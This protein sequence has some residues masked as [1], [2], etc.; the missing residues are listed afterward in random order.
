MGGY[1]LVETC[2]GSAALTLHLLGARRPLLPYQGG[3]WRVRRELAEV[4]RQR[5]YHGAPSQVV[6][7][8]PG[9]WG[10]AAGAVVDGGVRE[11]VIERLVAF[12]ERDPREVYDALAGAAVPAERDAFAAEYLFLQRLSFSG[13]AVGVR[14]DRWI[15]PGFNPSSAYGLAG[16][17]RFGAVRPM[18]PSLI[19]VLRD[20][21]SLAASVVDSH[22]R[23]A[24]DAPAPCTTPTVV[25]VD[26]PYAGSTAYPNGALSRPDVA[27]LAASWADAGALVV[28]SEGEPVQPLVD[29]G[30]SPVRL[31]AGRDDTS[32]FRGKQHE[33]V[34]VSPL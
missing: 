27:R 5:G 25:Y 4:L 32:P 12:A 26:P 34:T 9:P 18:I 28:V 8:D 33:W 11:R 16:T 10:I 2:C 23:E 1:T 29:R 17:D 24:A 21:D 22:R 14:D 7:T 19:G 31:V 13:K 20:Y 15:S 3:K 6:L 30:W